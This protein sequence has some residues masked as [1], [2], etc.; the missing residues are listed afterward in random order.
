[1]SK[2]L[3]IHIRTL[4]D[5]LAQSRRLDSDEHEVVAEEVAAQARELPRSGILS[6]LDQAIGHSK[7]RRREAV[8][9]LSEWTDV[10]DVVDRIGEWITDP[11]P[12]WRRWLI[13]TIAA[14]RLTQFAAH[15]RDII[16]EDPDEFC[17]DMAIH[18]AGTLRAPECLPVLL[19]LAREND[20]NLTWRLATALTCYATE[21]CRPYLEKWL[22]DVSL[23]ASTRIFAAWGLG[24]LGDQSAIH[25]LITM[26]DDPDERG[27]TYFRAGES[28]RAAQALCDVFGWP[29]EWDRSYVART[30]ARASQL[31]T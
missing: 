6:A 19:R 24:K 25:Y 17:R 10:P 31:Q 28:I 20:P 12:Q 2:E 21:E 27:E 11:D 1:M 22:R 30:K 9:L 3:T 8:Y 14:G 13:Q 18:A 7:S 23:C 5:R 4:L 26:L 29:F 15:L 16:E